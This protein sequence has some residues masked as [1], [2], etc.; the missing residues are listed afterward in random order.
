MRVSN[1][2]IPPSDHGPSCVCF[3]IVFAPG[4]LFFPILSIVLTIQRPIISWRSLPVFTVAALLF[5][6]L[7]CHHTR[8]MFPLSPYR[9]WSMLPQG[10]NFRGV[11]PFVE[12]VG[13]ALKFRNQGDP[14]FRS[15]ALA[16]ATMAAT[17]APW[18]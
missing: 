13:D 9:F 6:S 7:H 11:P 2:I 18:C 8:P 16:S 5:R 10:L 15:K 14:P 17:T 3:M 12:I 4:S 1:R